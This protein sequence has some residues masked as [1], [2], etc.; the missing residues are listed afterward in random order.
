MS[1]NKLAA[2]LSVLPFLWL[3]IIA[4]IFFKGNLKYFAIFTTIFIVGLWLLYLIF[5]KI[6]ALKPLKSS[7]KEN[8]LCLVVIFMQNILAVFL[9]SYQLLHTKLSLLITIPASLIVAWL[10]LIWLIK[11]P[12]S[13]NSTNNVSTYV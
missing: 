12:K 3:P 7:I 2:R 13:D 6:V 11:S 9:Y 5:R 8:L 1:G 10:C 4:G